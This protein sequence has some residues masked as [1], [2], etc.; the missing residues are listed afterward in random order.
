M[1]KGPPEAVFRLHGSQTKNRSFQLDQKKN[2]V[3]QSVKKMREKSVHTRA[4]GPR[5]QHIT[6]SI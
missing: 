3:K 2:P 5:R 6:Y 1:A 4:G